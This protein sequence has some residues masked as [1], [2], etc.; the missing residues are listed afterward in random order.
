ME[1]IRNAGYGAGIAISITLMA[2]GAT[3]AA[4]PTIMSWTGTVVSGVGTI[5]SVTTATAAGFAAA[6][7]VVPAAGIGAAA[8]V[9]YAARQRLR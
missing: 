2:Q 7:L 8:G 3:S 5:Q 6:P 1:A 4:L 9:L